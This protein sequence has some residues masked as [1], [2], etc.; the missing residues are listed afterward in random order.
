MIRIK[1][2]RAVLTDIEGTTGSIAFV[3]EISVSPRPPT[4]GGLVAAHPQ[5]AGPY[6]DEVRVAQGQPGLSDAQAVAVLLRW[7]TRTAKLP[8]LRAL[9]GLLRWKEG[10]GRGNWCALS[11]T[12]RARGLERWAVAGLRLYVYSSGSIEAQRLIFGHSRLGD[13]TPLFDGY[14]DTTSGPKIEAQ[15]YARIAEAIALDPAQ[16]LFLT[17]PP[18]LNW[19]RP[20]GGPVYSAH[21]PRRPRAPPG[22]RCRSTRL[23]STDWACRPPNGPKFGQRKRRS[24][25]GR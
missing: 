9:Q 25:G 16:V 20:H 14:F 22:P 2:A 7:M 4:H 24:Q 10:Y 21:R 23:R 15:S 12:T 5:A 17:D 8:P 19:S 18:G 13:L 1:G 3:Q 6:L 11:S